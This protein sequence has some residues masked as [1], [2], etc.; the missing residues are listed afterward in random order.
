MTLWLPASAC[1]HPG[2]ALFGELDPLTKLAVM[3]RQ[4]GSAWDESNVPGD[5]IDTLTELLE[6]GRFTP[7]TQ[8]GE[9]PMPGF[10]DAYQQ[11]TLTALDS[12]QCL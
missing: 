4:C 11:D 7:K 10:L 5:V 3:C 6:Q 8:P 12:R 9:R 2:D 1:P